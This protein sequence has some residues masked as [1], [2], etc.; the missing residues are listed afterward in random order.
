MAA[1]PL[2][3]NLA[4][5]LHAEPRQLEFLNGLPAAA[6]TQLSKD[7]EAAHKAHADHIHQ[8]MNEALEQIP[9]LLRAPIKKLFGL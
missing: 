9:W 4:R 1:K 6:Q 8:K 2:D 5:L 7:I 3:P